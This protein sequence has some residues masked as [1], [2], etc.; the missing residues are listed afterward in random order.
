VTVP[1]LPAD[2]K[3]PKD[4]PRLTPEELA[5]MRTL[6]GANRTLMAWIR[7]SL[8][9][10]SFGFTIYK[11]LEGFQEAEKALPKGHTPRT[12]GLVLTGM[13]T[14]AMLMGTSEYWQSLKQL[15]QFQSFHLSRF[16][17]AMA[18][19]MSIWGL[20]LFFSISLKIF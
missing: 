10:L 15:R 19:I 8:S 11:V 6:M 3:A 2:T 20:F 16:P 13:G 9:L 17:M 1:T 18:V 12:A 7:T 14:L 4:L 5:G